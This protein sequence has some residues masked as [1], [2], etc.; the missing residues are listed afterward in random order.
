MTSPSEKI[1]KVLPADAANTLLGK[2]AFTITEGV[3]STFE[4]IERQE[5]FDTMIN[6]Q[7]RFAA[8]EATDAAQTARISQIDKDVAAMKDQ[9]AQFGKT[10]KDVKSLQDR[11][12]NMESALS[13]ALDVMMTLAI[14]S[15][16]PTLVAAT[17]AAGADIGY[18]P[19]EIPKLT[20]QISEVQHFFTAPALAN[21][22]DTCTGTSIR[23]GAGVKFWHSH[24]TTQCWV[25]FRGIPGSQWAS[26]TSTIWFRVFGAADKMRVRANLCDKGVNSACD[27]E[28]NF[29]MNVSAATASV[30]GTS[31]KLTGQPAEGVF[32]IKMPGILEPFI[33]RSKSWYGESIQFTPFGG[34]T[35]GST[36]SYTVQLFS[37]IILD[38]TNVGRPLLSSLEESKVRFDLDGDGVKER[39]GWIGGFDGVGL[40]AMD[41]DG[42]GAIDGGRELFGE[43]TR[44]AHSGKKARDGYAALAQYDS[45]RDGMIDSKDAAY[46][47]LLVWFDRNKDG[48]SS[49]GE[50]VSLASTGVTK[51]AL[52][53]KALKD[54]G[55]F[56]NGN[57][58]RTTAKFWGPAQCGSSGCSSYDVYF[59]TAFTT[60]LK[61]K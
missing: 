25:N 55:R 36:R 7:K 53:H 58:L 50:L 19:R 56:V 44:L 51:V 42:N 54:A 8:N 2:M 24:G 13:K 26:A 32:D 35:A 47:K 46:S 39:T 41:L 20:P 43:G 33:R 49:A 59:S 34:P 48:Q 30:A 17:K 22:S 9:L 16:E 57:E 6:V 5:E 52:K 1:G 31:A 28:F 3:D 18:S 27:A 12:G 60:A 11:T 23:R 61:S 15:G 14:R 45:N 10:A 38:F 37:P 4:A 21:W 29:Q 40:L